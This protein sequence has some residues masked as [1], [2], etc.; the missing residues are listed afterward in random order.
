M[1]KHISFFIATMNSLIMKKKEKKHFKTSQLK[2]VLLYM[3]VM[4][5][6]C[7]HVMM[8]VCVEGENVSMMRYLTGM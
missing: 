6:L 3:R 8:Q 2:S 5:A 1:T 7:V 4:V